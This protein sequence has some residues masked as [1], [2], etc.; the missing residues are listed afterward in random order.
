LDDFDPVTRARAFAGVRDRPVLLIVAV[1]KAHSGRV[2]ELE[3]GIARIP[4]VVAKILANHVR[5]VTEAKNK[6]PM[7]VVRR[8]FHNVPETGDVILALKRMI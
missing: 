5:L 8:D 2:A 7:S 4:E 6:F 1:M 3:R